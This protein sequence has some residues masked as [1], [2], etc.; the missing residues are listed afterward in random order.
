MKSQLKCI[1]CGKTYPLDIK[2]RLCE[3]GSPLL[4]IHQIESLGGSELKSIIESRPL[5]VWR[6]LELLPKTL[7]EPVS[8]GEG[9]TY[10]Q[11]AERLGRELGLRN[12]YLKN[13]TMN[14]TGSFLDR[15][16]TVE[17][18]MALHSNIGCLECISRGNLAASLAAYAVKAGIPCKVYVL[19]GAEQAKILQALAYDAE[20]IYSSKKFNQPGDGHLVEPYN[21]FFLDGLKTSTLEILEQLDWNPPDAI[22]VTMGT[23]SNL[24]ATWKAL[25]EAESLGLINMENF[26]RLYGVQASGCAP[27]VEAFKKGLDKVEPEKNCKMIFP[28]ISEPNPILGSI[29]LKAIKSS[30]G[31][32][33]MVEEDEILEFIKLLAKTEGILAEP[34]AAA[35][36]A[37]LKIAVDDGLIDRSEKVV[38][39]ITGSGLKDPA[40]IREL[41]KLS[42]PKHVRVSGTK[43]KILK[44][45]SE[46]SMYGYELWKALKITYGL[47]FK[48]PTIYQH[49][50]ELIRMG[51]IVSKPPERGLGR[52]MVRKYHLTESGRRVL[53][54][55]LNKEP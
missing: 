45:L 17:V 32:A 16:S 51:L 2:L 25:N 35:S 19:P 1:Q 43:L 46:R 31:S 20:L 8:L 39:M 28:D 3:C 4:L 12:L 9:G 38:C 55:S 33:I 52:R 50:S 40:S 44:L 30:G 10:L 34:A 7:G 22:F 13:E 18:T 24:T 6:Y 26:P 23:G 54:D 36:I 53:A 11:R 27:I 15:G 14:P 42:Y 37:A 47:E 21:P 48:L 49:L 29:V 5:G 41:F